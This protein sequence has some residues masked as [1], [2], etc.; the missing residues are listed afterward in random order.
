MGYFVDGRASALIGTHTHVPT[1]DEQILTGGTAYI[2]D[3]GMC[4]DFDSVLGMDKEEPLHALPHQD[5]RAGVSRRRSARRRSAVSASRST[6]R[7]AC[8]RVIAP[9]RHRR[10][11]VAGR[12]EILA[13][14]K[15]LRPSARLGV[16]AD[17]RRAAVG[18]QALQAEDRLV[19][20][21]QRAVGVG[22]LRRTT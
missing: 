5:S 8:A 18:R 20:M 21:E 6:T 3:A 10:Q 1:A 9:L 22:A 17:S 14:A 12:A 2:S 4:G 7:R 19:E 11:V 15:S 13:G 16:L